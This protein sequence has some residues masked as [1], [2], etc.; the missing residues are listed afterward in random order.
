MSHVSVNMMCDTCG[1]LWPCRI[2]KEEVVMALVGVA[3]LRSDFVD[4][5]TVPQEVKDAWKAYTNAIVRNY[6][7]TNVYGEWR[8]EL[9]DAVKEG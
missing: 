8:M 7:I 4:L 1:V 6:K 2:K 3:G 5:D 9:L